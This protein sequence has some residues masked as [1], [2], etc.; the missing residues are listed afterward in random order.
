MGSETGKIL[1]VDD[2]PTNVAII[3]EILEEQ[4]CTVQAISTGEGALE[5]IN[6][7]K[8]NLVLLDIMMPGIDGYV[9]CRRIR[10]EDPS[11]FTKIILVS[12]KAMLEERLNGY[13]VGA[14]DYITKP[15]NEE[16]LLAKV[17]VFLR[18]NAVEEQLR[19]LNES[20]QD[21][22]EARSKQLVVA[23]RMAALGK[24]T[25]GIV[26]NLKNPLQILMG[27]AQLLFMDDPDNEGLEAITGASELMQMIVSTIL[28]TT[29][30]ESSQQSMEFDLNEV[31]RDQ[32]ELLKGN[33]FFKNEVK[34]EVN[35][36]PLPPYCGSY[37]HFSQVFGNLI[38][39]AVDAMFDSQI[40]ILII[41]TYTSDLKIIIRIS[42]TGCGIPEENIGSV[43]DS[44]FTTKALIAE[45]D[46]PTGTGLGLA[47]CKEMIE[48]YGGIILIDSKVD[49]GTTVTVSLP[50]KLE[51]CL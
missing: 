22:V 37:A 27:H 15:F 48:S 46:L 29:H 17:R 40:K 39:N 8:P 41:S 3:E 10:E 12:G 16:E 44:F 33:M 23:E 21:Q 20:L 35:L 51:S 43:F 31:L 2:D 36:K 24:H 25:A 14:D 38:G 6:E 45:D 18:L 32:L 13:K 1:I 30:R 42:D 50:L 9:V 19:E 34:T 5:V 11:G 47:F 28:T 49:Q 7:F 4:D 26:H